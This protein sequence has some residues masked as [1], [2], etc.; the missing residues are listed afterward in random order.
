MRTTTGPACAQ[1]LRCSRAGAGQS[2]DRGDFSAERARP[3]GARLTYDNYATALR[4]HRAA[5][6]TTGTAAEAAETWF[7][8]GYRDNTA[9][10]TGCWLPRQRMR[11][12]ARRDGRA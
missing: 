9:G 1:P 10:S 11:E 3:D 7:R 8:S 12:F 5:V 6:I 4:T 2:W